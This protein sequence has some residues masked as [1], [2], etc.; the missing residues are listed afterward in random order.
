[1]PSNFTTV[2][3]LDTFN[4]TE[5]KKSVDFLQPNNRDD[6]CEIQILIQ[7]QERL[8]LIRSIKN[9]V[10]SFS[11]WLAILWFST[12][13][14]RAK[15]KTQLNSL[16]TENRFTIRCEVYDWCDRHFMLEHLVWLV[17]ENHKTFD[18]AV[19]ALFTEKAETP[20]NDLKKEVC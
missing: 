1:M 2:L 19:S 9:P 10:E 20:G 13:I 6:Y 16:T 4:L 14:T 12:R 3:S 17:K 8:L 15:N 18:N 5:F 7:Y 11:H